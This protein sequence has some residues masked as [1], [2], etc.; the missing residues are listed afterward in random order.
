[1]Y[2]CVFSWKEWYCN[3]RVET[4]ESNRSI[5]VT[6]VYVMVTKNVAKV[7]STSTERA[8][9]ESGVVILVCFSSDSFKYDICD[10]TWNLP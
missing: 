9:K 8:W 1:M 4:R 5:S 6:V 7:L 2:V 10:M 3:E